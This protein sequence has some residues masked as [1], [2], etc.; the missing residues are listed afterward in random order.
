MT[1]P[2]HGMCMPRLRLESFAVEEA[3][4][5]QEGI[6]KAIEL[7]PD[8]VINLLTSEALIY[9]VLFVAPWMS[10]PDGDGQIPPVRDARPLGAPATFALKSGA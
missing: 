1:P 9:G 5:G 4:D 2:T 8:I 10:N 7:L 3:R 6:Q